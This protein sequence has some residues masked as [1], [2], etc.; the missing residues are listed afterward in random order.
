[1]ARIP[2]WGW[3]RG[4]SVRRAGQP[5]LAEMGTAFGLDASLAAGRTGAADDHASPAADGRL[6]IGHAAAASP[7]WWTRIGARLAGGR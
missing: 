6:A 4:R 3:L 5:D 2:G 1:M 7:R